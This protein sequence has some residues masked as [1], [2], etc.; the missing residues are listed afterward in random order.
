MVIRNLKGSTKPFES[1]LSKI[2]SKNEI[3]L[4]KQSRYEAYEVDYLRG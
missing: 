4:T 2:K 1:K 3:N